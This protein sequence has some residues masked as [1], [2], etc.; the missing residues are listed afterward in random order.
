MRTLAWEAVVLAMTCELHG[1]VGV[2]KVM[3]VGGGDGVESDSVPDSN[4]L[5]LSNC[6]TSN[7]ASSSSLGVPRYWRALPILTISSIWSW[8]VLP[9]LM[10]F[11]TLVRAE[12]RAQLTDSSLVNGMD[13][14]VLPS[15]SAQTGEPVRA[16]G[17]ADGG[18]FS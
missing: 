9:Q 5:M 3:L 11:H 17:G 2:G 10:L 13:A 7:A 8:Y 12:R 16:V 1:M 14:R 15:A 18:M 6:T 4:L